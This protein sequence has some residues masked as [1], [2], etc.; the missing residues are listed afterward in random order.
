MKN[1]KRM[2]RRGLTALLILAMLLS[3]LPLGGLSVQGIGSVTLSYSSVTDGSLY[4]TFVADA[5]Y[6][7][8]YYL[9]E[10]I[11]DGSAQTVLLD[12]GP[13]WASTNAFIW[14]LPATASFEIAG[15]T[16]LRQA[17][18]DWSEVSGGLQLMTANTMV[19]RKSGDTWV[20]SYSENTS[21]TD[22]AVDT[23]QGSGGYMGSWSYNGKTVSSVKLVSSPVTS[24]WLTLYGQVDVSG[25]ATDVVV[26]VPDNGEWW[27][28]FDS[29]PTEYYVPADAVFVSADGTGY[30]FTKNLT[31]NSSTG[32]IYTD[33]V[34]IPLDVTL[35]F[36]DATNDNW[37]FTVADTDGLTAGQWYTAD[38]TVDGVA[39]TVLLEYCEGAGFYIYGHCFGATPSTQSAPTSSVLI[40]ADTVLTPVSSPN[41][42][43]VVAGGQTL[44][45]TDEIHIVKQGGVWDEYVEQIV[46]LDVTLT[47]HDAANDNWRFTVAD[48]DGLTADQWYTADITVDGV[49]RTV[50]LQYC[51][52]AGFYIYGH[53][54]G[55]TPSTQSAP[56][57]SVLI[58]AGTVLTPVSSPNAADVVA[59]GQTLKLTDE[60]SVVYEYGAWYD[61]SM[62]YVD[63]D[64]ENVAS[65]INGVYYNSTEGRTWIWI[66]AGKAIPVAD[67]TLY[68]GAATVTVDGASYGGCAAQQLDDADD[69]GFQIMITGGNYTTASTMT[70]VAGTAY[71]SGNVVVRFINDFTIENVGGNW[72]KEQ[73]I[74]WLGADATL[75]GNVEL[76][77]YAYL[78]DADEAIVTFTFDNGAQ[79]QSYTQNNAQVQADGQTYR[80]AAEIVAAYMSVNVT[81]TL[82]VNGKQYAHTYS[83]KEYGEAV[84]NGNYSAASK[85]LAKAM[86]NYGG[87][88]QDYFAYKGKD[89]PTLRAN[90]AIDTTLPDVGDL[91]AYRPRRVT[92]GTPPT[93]I[94]YSLLLESNT[95][96]RLYFSGEPTDNYTYWCNGK[97]L[98]KY[99]SVVDGRYFVE[100]NDIG[101]LALFTKYDFKVFTDGELQGRWVI[102]PMTYVRGVLLN[103]DAATTEVN[104]MKALYAYNQAT[105]AYDSDNYG[106]DI[107][108]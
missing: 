59:G 44:Q 105:Q 20:P 70:V 61:Q 78:K 47:F 21:I 89:V 94:G 103:T 38:I 88:A 24:N 99:D 42:A 63:I 5:A 30:S 95:T 10:A 34:V 16:T 15:G 7:Q 2:F 31:V 49:A 46:P 13:D 69:Q 81:A 73:Q 56:T 25:T 8:K 97:E 18:G 33:P 52:G 54:F 32:A 60:I 6:A 86:L 64:A 87:Y 96:L 26:T 74:G 104:L 91:D 100:V 106:L 29:L 41:A 14:G 40:A 76:G 35:T 17:N 67:W 58:A 82:S 48:T 80:F 12:V 3:V 39:R 68:T 83:V 79:S 19:I 90:A 28:G 43:D 108:W 98:T 77:F 50:L 23:T 75:S 45:L 62:T 51:E 4:M 72:K 9:A 84:M 37:R 65:G 22:L 66:R 55:A 27:F 101:S 57:S 93:L 71:Y 11:V 92:Y 36:H 1:G 85:N 102:S 107:Q 53:C